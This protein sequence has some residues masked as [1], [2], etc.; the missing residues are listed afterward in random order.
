MLLIACK[1]QCTCGSMWQKARGTIALADGDAVRC[2]VP[3]EA[4]LRLPGKVA[5]V[6]YPIL[7]EA[8]HQVARVHIRDDER[9]DLRISWKV[10]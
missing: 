3:V 9:V 6:I 1:W 5:H 7:L 4:Q 10:G 8:P 2:A